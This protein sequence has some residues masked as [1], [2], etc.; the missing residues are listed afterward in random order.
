M[1][2]NSLRLKIQFPPFSRI[3]FITR[4]NE[5]G[6]YK[7][8]MR[9]AWPLV[10]SSSST[11]ILQLIDRIFL[12]WHS[13]LALSAA[14]IAGILS[15]SVQ[16]LFI[17]ILGYTA[18]FVAQYSGAGKDKDAVSIVKQAINVAVLLGILITPISMIGKSVFTAVGHSPDLIHYEAIVFRIF[19]LGSM[20]P[21]IQS[22][23][24]GY[25]IG[26]GKTNIILV[27][28]ILA[29]GLNIV[30]GY[31]LIFGIKGFIPEYGAAGAAV[32]TI[33]SQGIATIF[34]FILFLKDT[35]QYNSWG[36]SFDYIKR[37]FYYGAPNGLYMFVESIGWTLTQMIIGY[38][39]ILYSAAST[40]AFQLNSIAWMPIMGFSMAVS[41]MVGKYIGSKKPELAVR[42]FWSNL[43]IG[44]ALT[45]AAGLLFILIPHVLL[46][47]FGSNSKPE[48]FLPARDLATILLRFVAVYCFVDSL[49]VICASTLRGA[50]DVKFVM[51]ISMFCSIFLLTIPV[52]IVWKLF[53]KNDEVIYYIWIIISAMVLIQG[54]LMF[55]RVITGKWKKKSVIEEEMNM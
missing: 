3:K 31:I 51:I 22:A 37:L 41:T 17:A 9:L 52:C 14:A 35:S 15:W 47:P 53:G 48:E 34:Y 20:I 11:L 23:I 1:Q 18:V 8:A 44:L 55:L 33:I 30:L 2:D 49:Y 45:F 19:V 5:L 21:F 7:E 16:V 24:S 42:A 43:H 50:G 38:L 25:F 10:L 54:I 27:G 29:T 40:W 12:S 26:Y 4:W 13:H 6:G 36:I 28:S 32:A 46:A 39:G